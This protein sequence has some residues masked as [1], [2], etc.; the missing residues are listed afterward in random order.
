M[1]KLESRG[2]GAPSVVQ[3]AHYVC[4]G[5]RQLGD[6]SL[7]QALV[8]SAASGLVRQGMPAAPADRRLRASSILSA[9][10]LWRSFVA[11][12]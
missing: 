10:S 8:H 9:I 1:A 4:D 3:G 6:E 11:C 5:R 7:H 2:P 12:W